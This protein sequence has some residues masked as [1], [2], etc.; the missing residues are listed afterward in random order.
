MCKDHLP[1]ILEA[2]DAKLKEYQKSVADGVRTRTLGRKGVSGKA[3]SA[4][5]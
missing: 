3:A 5:N 2:C 4:L 1:Q